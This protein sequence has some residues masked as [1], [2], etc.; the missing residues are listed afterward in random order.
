MNMANSELALPKIMKHEK[1]AVRLF[2]RFV[3]LVSVTNCTA[4]CQLSTALLGGM[5]S[6]KDSSVQ[7]KHSGTSM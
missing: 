2:T 7:F 4:K 5:T 6:V 3:V 1:L